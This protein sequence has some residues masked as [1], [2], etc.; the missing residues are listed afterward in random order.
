MYSAVSGSLLMSK[1]YETL[2]SYVL[3][4]KRHF[5]NLTFN[6]KPDLLHP[7]KLHIILTEFVFEFA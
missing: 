1:T 6:F 4:G 2:C 3:R 7:L 5:F